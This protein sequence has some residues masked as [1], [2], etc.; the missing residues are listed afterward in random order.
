MEKY[1]LTIEFRYNDAPKYRYED[2]SAQYISKTIT[3]G[4]FDTREEANIIGNKAL[5]VFEDYFKLNP[6]YNRK[7]R[8]S[9]NGGCFGSPND[10]ITPLAY[11]QV[12]FDFY[13]K[14]TKLK[15][16]DVQLTILE[17]LEAVKRYRGFKNS[18]TD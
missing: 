4:V 9:N 16:E 2:V 1:L 6:N 8:F 3:L 18:N 5:E 7:E 15:Y 11:L 10:L 14:I 13:A 12:P 17:A